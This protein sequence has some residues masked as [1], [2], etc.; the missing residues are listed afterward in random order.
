MLVALG[1]DEAEDVIPIYLGDDRTDED[2]FKVL[3]ERSAGLG[4][5]ISSKVRL[6]LLQQ[7]CSLLRLVVVLCDGLVSI[8]P[9]A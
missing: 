7:H 9:M 3:K 4:I 2:A 6:R 1:L 5:L 8:R